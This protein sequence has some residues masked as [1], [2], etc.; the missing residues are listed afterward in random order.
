MFESDTERGKTIPAQQ[1]EVTLR[2]WSKVVRLDA[3]SKLI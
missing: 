3:K 1:K 2:L